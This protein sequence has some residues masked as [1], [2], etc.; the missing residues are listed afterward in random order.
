LVVA[1]LAVTVRKIYFSP[2]LNQR[3]LFVRA[4]H[5]LQKGD[6]AKFERL[7]SQLTNYPLYPYLVYDDLKQRL[8]TLPQNEVDNFFKQYSDT[9]ATT[10]LRTQWLIALASQQQW[11][12]FL[13]YYQHTNN[14]QLQCLYAQ[15]LYQTGKPLKAYQLGAQLWMIPKSQVSD[16]DPVF[17]VM[18]TNGALSEDLIWQR[19][20]LTI[21]HGKIDFARILAKQL[22][23]NKQSLAKRWLIVK[24]N[25]NQ[26]MNADLFPDNTNKYNAIIGYGL[27]KMATSNPKLAV[28]S[29]H[30]LKKQRKFTHAQVQNIIQAIAIGY[31]KSTHQQAIPWLEQI[32]P[33]YLNNIA[34]NWRLR[35]ALET[36]NWRGLLHWINTLPIKER[37]QSEW[38]YWKAQALMHVGKKSEATKVLK[39]LA[40]KRDYYGF[41][42][43]AKL[44]LPYPIHNVQLPIS[45]ADAK[46]VKNY[47]GFLRTQELF[48][49]NR[50]QE[51]MN[52]WWH[53]LKN[54]PESERYIATRLAN[55]Q[56][57]YY[58]ALASTGFIAHQDDL[59]LR[60]PQ[61]YLPL[62]EKHA[63]S[64]NLQPSF[65]YAIMRQESMFRPDV[66]SYAGAVGLMQLM[67]A[68]ANMLIQ[69][70]NLP[71]VYSKK[72]K[73]PMVNIRLGSQ[74]LNRLMASKQQSIALT[75]ASY[76]AG[77]GRVHSW[78]PQ[79]NAIPGDIWIDTI[80]YPETRNY[81]K[82][83]ITYAIIY[84]YLMGNEP[85][86]NTMMPAVKADK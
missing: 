33:K 43:A 67:P 28:S 46:R 44:N 30:K 57:W 52:E 45:D 82:N 86:I 48:A 84:Q 62:V 8:N 31:I 3:H 72:L 65:I 18:R 60:F 54:L 32:N 36:H 2:Q 63:N 35:F 42:A 19:F 39:K 24:Q 22:P 4:E 73:D 10:E 13:K 14:A 47:P 41:M 15:A 7:K 74:Y 70:D 59:Q 79:E 27:E 51:G 64:Y 78:L 37:K 77:P 71:R 56:G 17:D 34:M 26:I 16:C 81:V 29:W 68:T 40:T 23:D 12:Q 25:S 69:Q 61:F 75:A 83:V 21:Q 11:S 66:E 9:A 6:M 38:R 85:D 80:P 50:Q 20:L 76:N 49:L 5:A 53:F 55:Q 58:V 1:V